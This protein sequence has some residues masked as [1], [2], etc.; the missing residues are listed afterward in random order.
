MGPNR[1]LKKT[2]LKIFK[3]EDMLVNASEHALWRALTTLTLDK[4]RWSDTVRALKK[5]RVTVDMTG[6]FVSETTCKCT[7]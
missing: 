1:K 4:E 2:I 7:W 6:Y 5:P 3:T